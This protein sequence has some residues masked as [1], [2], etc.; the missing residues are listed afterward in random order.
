MPVTVRK[1]V[2]VTRAT[3]RMEVTFVLARL[4]ITWKMI[5]KCVQV[6]SS[7]NSNIV[8]GNHI[9]K[10]INVYNQQTF[11]KAVI[12]VPMSHTTLFYIMTTGEQSTFLAVLLGVKLSDAFISVKFDRSLNHSLA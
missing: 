6:R 9:R 12:H 4:A 7:L 3:I 11:I 1:V 8:T 5:S 2:V 10:R